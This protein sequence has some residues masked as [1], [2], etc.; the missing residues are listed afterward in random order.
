MGF[1]APAE[2]ARILG[3]SMNFS[4]LALMSLSG[5]QATHTKIIAPEKKL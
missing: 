3:E 2:A 5:V 4:R 1:H